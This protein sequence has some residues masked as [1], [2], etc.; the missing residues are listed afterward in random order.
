MPI[1]MHFSLSASEVSKQRCIGMQDWALT[2]GNLHRGLASYVLSR[3]GRTSKGRQGCI[4]ENP[5]NKDV[6]EPLS[7][8]TKCFVNL[9]RSEK[10]QELKDLV[11]S[12]FED[13]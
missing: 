9:S 10:F 7:I 11:K 12:K 3:T 6:A 13:T 1:S 4:N 5:L 8:L 2:E